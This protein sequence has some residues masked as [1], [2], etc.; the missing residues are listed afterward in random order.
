M[1]HLTPRRRA[2]RLVA[3]VTGVALAAAAMSGCATGG[4]AAAPTPDVDL[5]AVLDEPAELT[6]WSWSTNVQAVVDA[7]EKKYPKISIEVV[8]V[9]TGNDHYTKLQNAI[10]AGKGAPD[11]ATMEY[12]VVPQFALEDSIV[13]LKTFGFEKYEDEFTPAAWSAVNVGDGLYE[14]PHNSGPMALFYNESVF[15]NLGVEVPTTWDEYLDA[16]RE[17]H[18]ADPEAY[19]AA[20]TGDFGFT[21]SMIWAFGGQPFQTNGSEI[22]IDLADKGTTAFADFYQQLIDEDLLAPVSSWSDE[23]YKGLASGKIATLATGAWF[24][25]TLAS[26]VKDGAGQWR[27]APLPTVAKG[28]T[29]SSMNGGGGF[30]IPKQST[31]QAA[32]AAFLRYMETGEGR[33]IWIAAGQFPT[34]KEDLESADFLA[35]KNDYFGGQEINKIFAQSA[36]DALPGWQFLPYNSYAGTI[37]GDYVGKAYLG[38]ATLADALQ[39]WGD[40]LGEYG[41]EQGFSVNK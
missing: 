10:K 12:N 15:T 7:F 23:W 33:A 6:L 5:D 19:I 14:L 1:K 26:G 22:T 8:N 28:D 31:K 17:I 11:I 32:A 25:G 2:T 18:A 37:F 36:A 27:V 3:A 30:V 4:P 41:T 20:D 29:A 16:A 13:D 24:A 35:A 40:A 34:M 39:S 21:Q 9:G 38:E